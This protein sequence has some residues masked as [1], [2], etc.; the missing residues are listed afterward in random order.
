MRHLLGGARKMKIK[1]IESIANMEAPQEQQQQEKSIMA[2][3]SNDERLLRYI[4]SQQQADPLYTPHGPHIVPPEPPK[5]QAAPKQEVFH[6]GP[7]KLTWEHQI[8]QTVY[9]LERVKQ[10]YDM[11]VQ[12]VPQKKREKTM[13]KANEAAGYDLHAFSLQ[14]FRDTLAKE[15]PEVEELQRLAVAESLAFIYVINRVV[16]LRVQDKITVDKQQGVTRV[17][18]F[19]RNDDAEKVVK[20]ESKASRTDEKMD[21]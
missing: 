6:A 11:W 17:E 10:Q 20:P 16:K 14:N 15:F 21:V 13:R 12:T 19:G 3:M 4:I 9:V 2:E 18:Q 5:E 1:K 8:S 7:T